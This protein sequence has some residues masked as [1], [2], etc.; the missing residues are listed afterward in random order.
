MT[1]RK[2]KKNVN[3]GNDYLYN[4]MTIIEAAERYGVKL[5]TLRNKFK[6]S[7]T[8]KEKIEKWIKKGLIRQSGK[9]WLITIEFM[10][11]QFRNEDD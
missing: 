3:Q 2:N 9:T 5:D 11:S 8:N 1:Q 4:V 7:V 10:E 6:P